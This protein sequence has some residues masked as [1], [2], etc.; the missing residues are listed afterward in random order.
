M[1]DSFNF[2]FQREK[3]LKLFGQVLLRRT[4]LRKT[5]WEFCQISVGQSAPGGVKKNMPQIL[6]K[7]TDMVDVELKIHH[8]KFCDHSSNA[9]GAMGPQSKVIFENKSCFSSFTPLKNG[10]SSGSQD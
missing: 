3:C 1:I 6:T 10:V 7:L 2:F 9:D 8:I 5:H 4:R